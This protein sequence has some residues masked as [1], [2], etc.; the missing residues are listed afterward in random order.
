MGDDDEAARE[1]LE[2]RLELLDRLEVE[3]V[4]RLV[5]HEAV[6]AAGGEQREPGARALAGRERGAGRPTSSSPSA[7]FASSVRASAGSSPEAST[8]S[9]SS[10]PVKMVA[11]LVELAEDDRR[12]ERAAS[13][14]DERQLAERAPGSA[15]SCRSRSRRRSRAGR[16]SA[17]RARPGRGGT[18]RA[19]RRRR[20]ARRSRPAGGAAARSS[21]SRHGDHGFST[22]SSRSRWFFACLHLAAERVR[23]AAVGAARL[24]RQLPRAR[25]AGAP[26]C[27][28]RGAALE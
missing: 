24:P 14:R 5:E 6:D 21:R 1:R 22:S 28:G 4:R 16:P 12:A 8:K 27:A 18:S 15:S 26:A 20:R 17:A 10:T 7:N 3:V 19:R 11:R 9:S 2:R 13:P 23:R 25:R